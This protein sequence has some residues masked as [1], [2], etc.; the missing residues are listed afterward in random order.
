MKYSKEKGVARVSGCGVGG[1]HTSQKCPAIDC[2]ISPVD[3]TPNTDYKT[4][5]PP[6]QQ[7]NFKSNL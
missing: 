4:R 7:F 2:V 5:R 3:A 6:V 1:T